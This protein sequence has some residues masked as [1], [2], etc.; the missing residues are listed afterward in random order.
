MVTN[1]VIAET[2]VLETLETGVN[3]RRQTW[4]NGAEALLSARL[5]YRAYV[6]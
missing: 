6:V 5:S 3:Q 2:C 4:N 1:G